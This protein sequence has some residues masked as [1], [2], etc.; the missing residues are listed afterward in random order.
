M[1]VKWSPEE[2]N[3]ICSAAELHI[4][5]RRPDG[6]LR[7]WTP[8]WVVCVDEQVYVRTW[9]RR[10]TGWFGHALR[11]RRARIRVPGLA[12]DVTVEDLGQGEVDLHAAVDLDGHKA[13]GRVEQRANLT[14]LRLAARDESL[15]AKAR[16]DR[17]HED[18]VDIVELGLM[19]SGAR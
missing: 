19:M 3:S 15:P 18:E 1:I 11:S 12:A 16:V 13:V 17:H 14:D 5:V 7:R 10:E 2:L 8:I 9:Y 6:R 4:A